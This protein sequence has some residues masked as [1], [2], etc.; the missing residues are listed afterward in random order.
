MQAIYHFR[1]SRPAEKLSVLIRELESNQL[2]LVASQTGEA[3]LF[4]TRNLLLQLVRV[5]LQTIKVL[6]AIHWQ[7]LKIWLAGTPLH[8]KPS[9]P[10]KEIT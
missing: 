6:L 2:L 10:A 3:Q 1:L 9:P 4:N 5:P 8:S 7:A